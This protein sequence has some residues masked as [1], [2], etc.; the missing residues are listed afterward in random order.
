MHVGIDEAGRGPLIG[1]MVVAGVLA[2]PEALGKLVE[3]GLKD[4]KQLSPAKRYDL[5]KSALSL[6][7][8]AVAVY[9]PPWRIERENLN[10]IE[11]KSIEWILRTM[12]PLLAEEVRELRVY[13]DEIKGRA[14]VL[15]ALVKKVFAEYNVGFTMEAGADSKYP[16]VALASVVAKVSRD[17]SL[18]ALKE[19][20][21]DFGSGYVTDS[22]TRTWVQENSAQ[23][24]SPP[25]FIRAN[26][27]TL[28][29]MAPAW[30]RCKKAK[31]TRK[32]RSLL[33]YLKQ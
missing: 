17:A 8:V 32:Q 7:V 5:Y 28:K 9:V 14:S 6:G 4:S 23:C 1:D 11:V 12:K 26:W 16:A 22:R 20:V 33:D 29:K 21:G 24:T 10:D 18:L 3:R 19:C 31:G 25:V 15:A 2:S 13:V 27:G 30:Y